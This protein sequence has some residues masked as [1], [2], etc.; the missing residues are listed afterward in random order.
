[1]R[2]KI[3]IISGFF[4]PA[5]SGHIKYLK[6]AKKLGD[7]LFVILN[8]DK[9]VEQKGRFPFLNENERFKIIEQ[10]KGVDLV[11]KA[12]DEDKT[13]C[14][15]LRNIRKEYPQEKLIFAN[16]GDRKKS[17]IPEEKIC[18]ELNI[19]SVYNVGGRKRNSSSYIIDKVKKCSIH[20]KE[21][22]YCKDCLKNKLK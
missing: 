16:G 9:Q 20:N 17:N 11:I 1:M 18:K 4:N 19:K 8:T 2:N 10:F 15:T 6:G 22:I 12:V 5:H 3:V 13:V 21:L 7:T 14:E